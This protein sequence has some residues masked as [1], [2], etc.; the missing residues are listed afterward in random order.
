[1]MPLEGLIVIDLT[2]WLGGYA[3]RLMSD[4]GAKVVHVVSPDSAR[5]HRS[6]LPEDLFNHFGKIEEVRG[7]R[8]IV[9]GSDI[10]DLLHGASILLTDF[11][12]AQLQA[13]G[14]H[15][16]D[17]RRR[18]PELIHVAITPHGMT[19]PDA[20]LPATD[21]TLLADGGLLYLSG[22]ADRPPVRPVA[23]Q[24]AV[25][26]SLHATVATLIAVIA[27]DDDGQGQL[28]DVSAQEAVAHSVENAVQYFDCERFI[29]GRRGVG[30]VEAGSGLFDCKDGY[31]YILTTMGGSNLNWDAAIQWL[32]DA[33]ASG[34]E[35]LREPA[36]K[37]SEF[38][39]TPRA[40]SEFRAIFD[41]Y[42]VSRTRIEI[43]TEGQARG[44]SVAPVWE[45]N[46]LLTSDQLQ[47][48]SFFHDVDCDGQPLR[49]PG[50]P[51]RFLESVVGRFDTPAQRAVFEMHEVISEMNAD[52]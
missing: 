10:D 49:F 3:G 51:Y 46:D 9:T 11:A 38:R 19:G 4:L 25:V 39:R 35:R 22:D 18:W 13:R 20:N 41:D 12:P 52:L 32:I 7:T 29:R 43:T 16:D 36:W 26:T 34:S 44:I 45:P 27:F 33:G 1:M 30:P 37:E 2:T 17:T 14:L 5:Q 42:A 23:Q 48:R 50:L 8:G 47:F 21:L 28:V 24:A 6:V 15:P 31:V 40:I